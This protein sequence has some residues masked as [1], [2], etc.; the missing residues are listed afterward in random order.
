MV[1][2][3]SPGIVLSSKMFIIQ[4]IVSAFIAGVIA[5]VVDW[6]RLFLGNV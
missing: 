2:F 5:V 6:K 3:G 1:L 4:E